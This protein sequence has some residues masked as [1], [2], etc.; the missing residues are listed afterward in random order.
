MNKK[1]LL[2]GLAI[3]LAKLNNRHPKQDDYYPLTITNPENNESTTI[4]FPSWIAE[5]TPY[6]MYT[7]WRIY[8]MEKEH[9]RICAFIDYFEIQ[10]SELTELCSDTNTPDKIVQNILVLVARRIL[11]GQ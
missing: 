5:Q 8:K 3:Y 7:Y 10:Y 6:P 1:S 4:L 11:R 2:I 9:L